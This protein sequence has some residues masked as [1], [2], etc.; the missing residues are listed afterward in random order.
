MPVAQ[1]RADGREPRGGVASSLQAGT[2]PFT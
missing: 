1:V 2:V